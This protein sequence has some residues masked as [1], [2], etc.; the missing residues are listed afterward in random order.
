MK[1]NSLK[2]GYH[3]KNK[4]IDDGLEDWDSYLEDHLN[5]KRLEIAEHCKFGEFPEDMLRDRLVC[6]LKLEHTQNKLYDISGQGIDPCEATEAKESS[7]VCCKRGKECP[8]WLI[9]AQKLKS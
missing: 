7:A 4:P 3:W 1:I 5:L 9:M 6:S 2:H 8:T